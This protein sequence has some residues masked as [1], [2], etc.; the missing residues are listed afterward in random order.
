MGLK[1]QPLTL[2]AQDIEFIASRNFQKEE[3]CALFRVPPHMIG[4]AARG[5]NQNITQQ[6]QDY[7]NNTL[8]TFI[9]I[10]RTRWKFTFSLPPDTDADFDRSVLL[11][12]DILAR[13]QMY[14]LGLQGVLSTNEARRFEKLGPAPEGQDVIAGDR[15]F[16]PVNMAPID[17]DVF[18]GAELPGGQNPAGPGSDVTGSAPPG[19]GDPNPKVPDPDQVA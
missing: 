10:W 1:W 3:I 12:G 15:V 2:S 6:S 8:S 7:V 16:R 17:A 14:R 11:E 18:L 19:A 4:V 5:Q 13:F 9:Q